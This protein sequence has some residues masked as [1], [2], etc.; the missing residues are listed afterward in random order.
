MYIHTPP[1]NYYQTSTPVGHAGHANFVHF[2]SKGKNHQRTHGS[3]VVFMVCAM[4]MAN[5]TPARASGTT[6]RTALTYSRA[7]IAP[8]HNRGVTVS[9]LM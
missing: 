6:I 2:I 3:A 9:A 4:T 5:T 7:I 8:S 1:L